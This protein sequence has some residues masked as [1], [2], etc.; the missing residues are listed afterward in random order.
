MHSSLQPSYTDIAANP[1]VLKWMTE[2]TKLKKQIKGK[3]MHVSV[4]F[5][6]ECEISDS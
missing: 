4:M 1:K 5:T 2:L 6:G 3:I